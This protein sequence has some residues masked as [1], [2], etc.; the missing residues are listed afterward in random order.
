MT[1]VLRIVVADDEPEIRDYF[2][3]ILPRF[4]HEVVGI[5]ENGRDLVD[6][7]QRN[8]PDLV[9]TDL[10]MPAISGLEAIAVIQTTLHIPIIVVSSSDKPDDTI[11]TK[12]AEF[13]VKPIRS[14][15]L[16]AAIER[17]LSA[18]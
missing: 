10:M 18:V 14:G 16:R 3:R 15:D 12:I 17:A 13:L 11:G 4:G 8:Q 9:I 6:L 5:A 1:K 7:C 2:R